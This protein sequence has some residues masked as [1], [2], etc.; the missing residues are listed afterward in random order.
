[1][2]AMRTR[3]ETVVFDH[4][5]TID[6]VDGKHPA[7]TYHV[8]VDEELL[9]NLSFT[10]YRRVQT[11]ITLRVASG[12]GSARQVITI[13]AAALAAAL[14]SDKTAPGTSAAAD[15]GSRA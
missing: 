1:M 6:G 3:I 14:V 15:A 11:T 5:F 13:D 10:A 8:E 12:A 2:A 9:P 7:G 4:P